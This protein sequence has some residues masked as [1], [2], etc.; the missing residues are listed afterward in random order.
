MCQGNEQ[1]TQR[2][3]MMALAKLVIGSPWLYRII[4]LLF[5]TNLQLSNITAIIQSTQTADYVSGCA[6]PWR[7]CASIGA[8]D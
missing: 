8:V 5:V 3:E 4:L 6:Q 1:F 2:M 7:C